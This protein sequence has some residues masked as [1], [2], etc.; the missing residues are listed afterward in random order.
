VNT[1][2]TN[3]TPHALN[4]HDCDD[5]VIT[6]APSGTVA[7]VRT[8]REDA[9]RIGTIVVHQTFFL[10][11]QDLPEPREGVVYVVSALVRAAVPLREDVL[12]PGELVR[13][14]AGQ[15]VGCRGLTR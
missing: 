1:T 4:I 13:N 14:E 9:G 3:L 2:I 8:V 15:P 12:S 5:N 6:V 10:E 11:V 7:R